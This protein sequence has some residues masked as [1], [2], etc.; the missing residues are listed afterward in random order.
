[1]E[2][3]RDACTMAVSPTSNVPTLALWRLLACLSYDCTPPSFEGVMRV[4]SIVLLPPLDRE[5]PMTEVF[6]FTSSIFL[7][8]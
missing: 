6:F 1:V 8:F 3:N 5:F 2:G 7:K 4:I